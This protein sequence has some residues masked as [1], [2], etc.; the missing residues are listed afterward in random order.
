MPIISGD[1][2]LKVNSY[3]QVHTAP[4]RNKKNNLGSDNSQKA[5]LKENL[6]M[7]KNKRQSKSFVND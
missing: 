1:T 5:E 6:M 2:H 3:F 4:R 7:V